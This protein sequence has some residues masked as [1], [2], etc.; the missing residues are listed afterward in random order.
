MAAIAD[1]GSSRSES[2]SAR[3]VEMLT[4]QLQPQVSGEAP[5]TV[6]EPG[7]VR[8]RP[9]FGR[10]IDDGAGQLAV[11]GPRAP[12]EVVAADTGPDVIDHADLGV[13]VDRRTGVVLHV[14]HVHP[15]AGGAT[16][17]LHRLFPAD[18]IGPHGQCPVDVGIPRHHRDQVQ[19]RV[20]AQCLG[21]KVRD[22]RG[23]QVLVL[24]VDEASRAADG[25][26]VAASY[27]PFA[28]GCERV[29][30]TRDRV[31]AQH[32]NR[33]GSTRWR[34]GCSVGQLAWAHVVTGQPVADPGDGRVEVDRRR[35]GPAFPKD[36]VQHT[37]YRAAQLEL[38]VMPGW[39]VAVPS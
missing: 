34:I 35:I 27:R 24:D 4:P 23:P 17:Q 16:A 6:A 18:E 31:G 19:P 15:I 14:E 11:V 9:A 28:L 8:G 21:E 26:G 5:G 25:L 32:L 38:H 29:R 10:G 30:R 13:H 33:M 3:P 12:V 1:C 2:S 37:D 39:P 36:V 22:V 7:R 20:R